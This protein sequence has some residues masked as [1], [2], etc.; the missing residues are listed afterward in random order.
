MLRLGDS[1]R[2]VDPP[3]LANAVQQVAGEALR[4]YG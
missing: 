3:H 4:N 2:V 1:A